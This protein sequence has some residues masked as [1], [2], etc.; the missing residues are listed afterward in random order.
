MIDWEARPRSQVVP[1]GEADGDDDEGSAADGIGEVPAGGE[2]REPVPVA[3]DEERPRLT[4][5][6]A[7]RPAAGLEDGPLDVGGER[8]GPEM[9][10]G[11]EA[12]DG[13]VHGRVGGEQRTGHGSLLSFGRADPSSSSYIAPVDQ[14]AAP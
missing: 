9:A 3:D 12:D 4:V 10:D 14:G 13:L 2:S 1:A 11:A 7:P 6:R 5:L 8:L